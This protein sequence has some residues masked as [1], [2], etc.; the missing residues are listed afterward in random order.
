MFQNENPSPTPR[1]DYYGGIASGYNELHGEEQRKKL[2]L[3][4]R[5]LKISRAT[6]LLDVGCGTGLSSDFG[7]FVVGID[8]SIKLLKL[9][10]GK[11]VRGI[12][13]KLP[14]KDNSFDIVVSLTAIH[15]F[16]DYESAIMEMARVSRRYIIIGVLK[17]SLGYDAIASAIAKRLKVK[18]TVQENKDTLFFCDKI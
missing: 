11:K 15:N 16:S 10:P 13:E 8:P 5:S 2:A 4:K 1:H 14:F 12:G 9:N 18:K 3:V 6:R 17:K 7:C